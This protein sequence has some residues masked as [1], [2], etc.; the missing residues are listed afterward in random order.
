MVR[1]P[2]LVILVKQLRK[3]GGELWG[4]TAEG[5]PPTADVSL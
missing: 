4:M 1:K 5:R 3:W 2:G